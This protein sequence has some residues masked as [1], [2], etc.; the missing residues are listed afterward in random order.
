MISKRRMIVYCLTS[1]VIGVGM[2][3]E[4]YELFVF[5]YGP[6]AFLEWE[7]V[8]FL[9][10]IVPE[11]IIGLFCFVLKRKYREIW[12]DKTVRFICLG[13]LISGYFL[14]SMLMNFYGYQHYLAH[15]VILASFISRFLFGFIFYPI[16]IAVSIYATD[17]IKGWRRILAVIIL[18]IFIFWPGPLFIPA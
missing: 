8:L 15:S 3:F 17:G 4:S 6:F 12:D 7:G 13:F 2:A 5:T 1:L 14:P 10:Y 11:A 16:A 18:F 9:S